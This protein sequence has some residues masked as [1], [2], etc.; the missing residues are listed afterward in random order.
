MS[1]AEELACQ[2]FWTEEAFVGLSAARR[3]IAHRLV[4]EYFAVHQEWPPRPSGGVWTNALLLEPRR[5]PLVLAAFD[6]F[7]TKDAFINATTCLLS[8]KMK[9]VKAALTLLQVSEDQR[10]YT[11]EVPEPST[12]CKA[13]FSIFMQY[14]RGL[15]S[16][17]VPAGVGATFDA[18]QA[19]EAMVKMWSTLFRKSVLDHAGMPRELYKSA[20]TACQDFQSKLLTGAGEAGQRMAQVYAATRKIDLANLVYENKEERELV[21]KAS[22]KATKEAAASSL[23]TA[24]KKKKGGRSFCRGCHT[25]FTGGW[26]AHARSSVH[27]QKSRSDKGSASSAGKPAAKKATS[28]KGPTT[29][30]D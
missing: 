28:S 3:N 17:P 8:E 26:Y 16:T 5:W 10:G 1:T 12:E 18:D 19:V 15:L 21:R 29:D 13:V 30:S 4:G 14:A 25:T 7:T 22:L 6:V 9:S 27:Q 23:A 11:H 24:E 2:H 20:T